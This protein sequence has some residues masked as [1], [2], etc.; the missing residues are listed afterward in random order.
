[1]FHCITFHSFGFVR[2]D[3]P[4]LP[5]YRQS[6]VGFLSNGDATVTWAAWF[7]TWDSL[8]VRLSSRRTVLISFIAFRLTFYDPFLCS[9]AAT[10]TAI[11]EVSP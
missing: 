7:R 1:M 2:S 4:V 10:D 9:F 11:S 8:S 3:Q 5:Q 6:I